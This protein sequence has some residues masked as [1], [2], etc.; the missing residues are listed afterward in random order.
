MSEQ[1]DG[2]RLEIT[3]ALE[4]VVYSLD[5]TPGF[6]S[7]FEINFGGMRFNS[8]IDYQA[9]QPLTVELFMDGQAILEL[10]GVF[11]RTDPDGTSVI[12]FNNVDSKH[13]VMLHLIMQ[14]APEYA[15]SPESV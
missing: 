11:I 14:S 2:K 10:N 13:R 4:A 1:R 3:T 12:K 9:Q 7:K 8:S 5:G 15:A 6:G